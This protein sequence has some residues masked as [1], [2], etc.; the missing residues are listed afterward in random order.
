MKKRFLAFL[1]PVMLFGCAE[2]PTERIKEKIIG[3]PK[4]ERVIP[5]TVQCID[6]LSGIVIDNSTV[7]CGPQL[8]L[9]S[10]AGAVS[11]GSV[12]FLCAL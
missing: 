9:H 6:T 7:N 5:V 8:Q 1:I 11:C 10:G 12:S 3:G 4:E 2:S